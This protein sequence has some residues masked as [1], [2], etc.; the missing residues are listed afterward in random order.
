SRYVFDL[1][2]LIGVSSDNTK[3]K[4]TLTF[5]AV[6][7][8][9]LADAQAALPPT[10]ESIASELDHET[11]VVRFNFAS[12]VDV[13]TFREDNSYVVDV[14]ATERK[15]GSKSNDTVVPSD[16]LA[17][18]AAELAA[19]RPPAVEAPQTMPARAAAT[20]PPGAAAEAPAP[21]PP[22]PALKQ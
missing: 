17:A 14:E 9:D 20:A 7:R 19:R 6:L 18:L 5:D 22:P 15:A 8:F 1:P 12:K 2:E 21:S 13:R 16:S 4:L 3:D 10:I 11:V